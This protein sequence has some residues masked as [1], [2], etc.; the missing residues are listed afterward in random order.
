MHEVAPRLNKVDRSSSWWQF[1]SW[2]DP[3]IK[4]FHFVVV[5]KRCTL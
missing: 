2:F 5:A 1:S 3:S 4:P